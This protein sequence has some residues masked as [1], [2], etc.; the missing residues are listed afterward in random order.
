MSLKNELEAQAERSAATTA[1][2]VTAQRRA[3]IDAVE[4]LAGNRAALAVGDT[5]PDFDLPDA[6]GM[7][8][9]LSEL[10]LNGPVVVS[11]YRGGW[12]PYC[13]LELRALQAALPALTEAGAALVAISPDAPDESLSTAEKAGL[14]FS[15][16][17]DV[18]A[19]T[20]IAYGLN[21]TI[22]ATTRA[23]LSDA[24]VEQSAA[25]GVETLVLPS[26]P[27]GGVR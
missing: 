27:D 1:P 16:L 9:R 23:V 2:G 14:E 22:D 17:S 20:I 26:L 10:V 18:G 5:A 25:N 13:N 15:V 24:D 21:Y 19:E 12:C 11:F 4:S 8:V 7:P 6:S 3:A